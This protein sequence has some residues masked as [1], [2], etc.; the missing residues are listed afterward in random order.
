[1]YNMVTIVSNIVLYNCNLLRVKFKCLHICKYK[2]KI[3][4]VMEF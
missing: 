4:D 1:M 3:C 2:K